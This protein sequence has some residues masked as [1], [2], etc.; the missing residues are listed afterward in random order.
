AAHTLDAETLYLVF[1]RPPAEISAEAFDAWYYDHL[2]ENVEIG[3]MASAH[4]WDVVASLVDPELP[5]HAT[6]VAAYELTAGK[7]AMNALLNAAIADGR[8][9]LPEWFPGITFASA[10]ITAIGERRGAR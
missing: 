2:R 3:E 5:P 10:Q 1:A 7:D 6:H 8:I 9:V 4:R